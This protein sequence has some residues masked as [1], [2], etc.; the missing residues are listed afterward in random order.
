MVKILHSSWRFDQRFTNSS[1]STL[2]WQCRS[3]FPDKNTSLQTLVTFWKPSE[4]CDF[5]LKTTQTRHFISPAVTEATSHVRMLLTSH[6]KRTTV[7]NRLAIT[8]LLKD[9]EATLGFLW[10]KHRWKKNVKC[11]LF[12]CKNDNT[13]LTYGWF[14][15]KSRIKSQQLEKQ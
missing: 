11:E 13:Y 14:L 5:F 10:G 12:Y 7:T 2:N 1:L 3:P 6:F 9:D 4:N 8:E 15:R